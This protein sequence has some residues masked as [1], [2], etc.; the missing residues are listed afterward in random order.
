[1]VLVKFNQ[2][3]RMSQL[4][5]NEPVVFNL[6]NADIIYF[7]QVFN[8]LECEQFFKNFMEHVNWRE[9][10]ITL[11][12]KTYKQPRLTA[13]Y[14]N[15]NKPYSY[16]NITMHPEIFSDE[17]E[18]IK[19]KVEAISNTKFTT[20]LLNLYRNGMDSNGWHADD[21]TA[22]G[23]NPIIASVSFGAT[24]KFQLKHN[25]IKNEKLTIEL[26][27][28]SLL[29]MQGTTQHFWKHQVPKTRKEIGKR[30]NLTFRYIK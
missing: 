13:L 10:D 28:G 26:Q 1:M 6:K 7:P 27:N 22:L 23:I 3:F 24:R 5:N 11:F 29:L 8:E 17:L 16:S 15:N 21:E 20:C 14:A 12:G 19:K 25:S 2:F 9:D 18:L 30:I 4:F